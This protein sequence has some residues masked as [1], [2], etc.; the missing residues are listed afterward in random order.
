MNF[1]DESLELAL[2]SFVGKDGLL[3]GK[4]ESPLHLHFCP[5]AW[6]AKLL[7]NLWGF[8][9]IFHLCFSYYI[10][11][12]PVGIKKVEIYIFLTWHICLALDVVNHTNVAL[13]ILHYSLMCWHLHGTWR[14]H[15]IT[16]RCHCFLFCT[17]DSL[18]FISFTFLFWWRHLVYTFKGPNSWQATVI[19]F[20][21]WFLL[22]F[23]H[24]CM[25]SHLILLLFFNLTKT[26]L[27]NQSCMQPSNK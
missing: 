23:Q 13:H 25:I 6:M 20:V 26:T 18:F 11:Q 9:L 21:W 1:I 19:N 7:L 2:F 17:T 15:V 8:G 16:E 4:K 5:V 27:H 12:T 10:L 22:V 3:R 14:D 24:Y